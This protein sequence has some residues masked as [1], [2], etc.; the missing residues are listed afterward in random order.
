MIDEPAC[1]AGRRISR[2]PGFRP[3][4]SRRRSPQIFSSETAW[5]LR[6]PETST[7]TSAFCVASTRFSA[8]A[9]PIPVSSRKVSDDP[10]NELARRGQ[11]GAD[12][13][14]A[15]VHDAQPLLAFVDAPA[16]A[17]D[18]LGIGAHFAAQRRQHRILQLGAADLHHVRRSVSPRP[19]RLPATPPLAA[20][21]SRSPAMAASFN[22]V[23]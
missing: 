9:K 19:E 5:A 14:A 23:G 11:P 1:R 10:E 15:Q 8:R 21:A 22:A 18:G 7:N 13:G 12:G 2:K 16:V 4:A 20:P 3:G 6:M 17:V